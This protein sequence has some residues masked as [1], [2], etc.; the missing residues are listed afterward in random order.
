MACPSENEILDFALGVL[1]PVQAESLHHHLD[2]CGSCQRLVGEAARVEGQAAPAPPPPPLARGATVDRYLILEQL[3]VGGMG[4]VYAAFDPQLDRKV[5][6]KLLRADLG[7]APE[8]RAR[9]LGEAQALARLSN[10]HVV[11]VYEAKALGD[12]V[13]VAMELV[14]GVTLRQWLREARRPWREVLKTVLEAGEGLRAAHEAGVVHRDVK[15]DNVL[16]GKRG[17]VFVTDFGLA[18][19]VDAQVPPLPHVP[20]EGAAGPD[21]PESWS[22]VSG[23]LLGTPAYMAPEQWD[24]GEV[25]ARTDQFSFCITVYEAL[26]GERPFPGGG[27]SAL[28]EAVHKGELRAP[29]KEAKVPSHLRRVLARGL[30]V[31]PSQRYPNMAALLQALRRDPRAAWRKPLT[32]A[33]AALLLAVGVA[34]GTARSEERLCRGSERHLA[35]A[36]DAPRKAQVKAALLSSSS[37]AAA[38]AWVGV[39]RALDTYASQWAAMHQDACEATRVRGEQSEAVLDLRMTCLQRRA[40]DLQALTSLF[41]RRHGEE[42]ERAVMAAYALPSLKECAETY[43]LAAQVKPPKDPAIIERVE[44]VNARLSHVRALANSGQFNTARAEA[45]AVVALA[46]ALNHLPTRAE[47]YYQ[48]ALIR[49]RQ[50]EAANAQAALLDA[51]YAAEAG[52]HDRLAARARIDLVTVMGEFLAQHTLANAAIREAEAAVA[53]VGSDPEME[54]ALASTI[55]GAFLA[56][57]RC[58]EALVQLRRALRLGDAAFT[59]DDPFRARILYVLGNTQRCVG[60]LDGALK[61][62]QES[63]SLQQRVFGPAHPEVASS[64]NSLGNILFTRQKFAEALSYHRRALEVRERAFGN[65][66]ALVGSVLM[67]VGVDLIALKQ[68]AEG[69]DYVQRTL[70]IYERAYGPESPRLVKPLSVLGHVEVDLG[71]PEQAR[72]MLERALRL[73]K[74]RDDIETAMARFNLAR[75]LRSS[76]GDSRRAR[77]LALQARHYYERRKDARRVELETIDL[78]LGSARTL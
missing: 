67:N 30:A 23:E 14:E 38:G 28:K 74:D 22:T 9:L 19:R 35:D 49:M 21:G 54:S 7:A 57:D 26:Y 40:R 70:D 52:H 37:S 12:Q 3:G 6:L 44:Q 43:A 64:F 58:E 27:T 46:N 24:G 48:L 25:D 8:R 75:A 34:I 5:A 59:P 53:R 20:V 56:Q 51:L 10:P 76:Q 62:L 42:V 68:S 36:W 66:N 31:E 2:S 45:E 11:T 65:D 50:G 77:N 17:R 60:D 15:P 1:P 69:R 13:F 73:L 47:A 63:L 33:T 72:V 4:V 16:L 71:H 29:R 41:V 18:R 78:W 39:E 61:S 55:G 32:L